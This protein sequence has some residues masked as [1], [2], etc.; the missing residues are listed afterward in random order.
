MV[1][2]D[3]LATTMLKRSLRFILWTLALLA[4]LFAGLLA[5]AFAKQD[6][7]V[8]HALTEINRDM[9]GQLSVGGSHIAPFEAFPLICIDLQD[10][11]F[12]ASDDSTLKMGA[13]FDLAADLAGLPRPL[14]ITRAQAREQI[15]PM[16]LSFMS[17]SRQLANRRL[18]HE[19][20]LR[21]QYPTVH[22]G[23]LDGPDGPRGG[24][25]AG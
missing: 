8:Q 19:L 21:L 3:I 13:Y 24:H 16:L 14:R 11:R 6:D 15:S 9:V 4:L 22:E 10:V 23:L 20:R 18:K 1:S 5:M 2:V 17:E 12:H 7:L 25:A